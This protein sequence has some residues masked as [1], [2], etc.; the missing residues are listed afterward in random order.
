ME[1]KPELDKIM[2]DRLYEHSIAPP[3]FVWTNIKQELR[4][5][6]RKF[7][8]LWWFLG[9]GLTATGLWALTSGKHAAGSRQELSSQQN[10]GTGHQEVG[11]QQSLSSQQNAGTGHQKVGT[12]QSLSSQQ[13]AGTGHQEVGTQQSLSSQQSLGTRQR[14]A[15]S[16]QELS[17]QQSAG[18]GNQ[19]AGTQQSLSSQQNVGTMQQA[20]SSRQEL[21][22]QQNVGTMQ[23]AAGS[24]QRAAGSGQE[25]SSQQNVRTMQQAAGTETEKT[26]SAFSAL[27]PVE[28]ELGGWKRPSPQHPK[29][30]PIVRKK[31]DSK[32]CYDFEH[33]GTVWWLDAYV[34]PSITRRQFSA[35]DSEYDNYLQQRLETERPEMAFNAGIRANMLFRENFVVRSG[36]HYDQFVEKFEWADP[37]SIEVNIR[38]RTQLVNGVWETVIDTLSIEYGDNY[39]KTYN[40]FGVLDIPLELGIELRRGRTGVSINGGVSV[41]LLFWK[42][43]AILSPDNNQ[44]AYFTPE[45]GTLEVF[46][47]NAGV[48]INGS[49]QWFYHIQP[50]LRLF[51]EP[52]YRQVVKPLTLNGHPVDQQYG[53][54]GLKLGMTK[55]LHGK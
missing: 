51:V 22:S 50:T 11:T 33:M 12:Q 2:Q 55:I 44:P 41:N 48:S 17:S 24:R 52:Y 39:I 45:E 10:A 20:A 46:K 4:R 37:N 15:G 34:G 8:A 49:V 53:I 3:D 42:R 36:F 31:Q 35:K 14:A 26:I 18:T 43:G 54:G 30:K 5:K 25:L 9:I 7:V 19:A 16:G 21:S 6:R 23:Q 27:P 32:N 40:R 29:V 47:T 1:S 13:N 38:T 28:T